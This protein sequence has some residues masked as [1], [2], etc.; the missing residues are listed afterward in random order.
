MA[1]CT[2][3]TVFSAAEV[4]AGEE[5]LLRSADALHQAYFDT[6]PEL[7][8]ALSGGPQY[9]GIDMSVS[10]DI[11]W[12]KRGFT[13]LPGLCVCI[14]VLTGLVIDLHVLSK[15]CHACEVNSKRI[16]HVVL[17]VW[18]AAH[19]RDCR[20]NHNQSSKAME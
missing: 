19:A 13:Y 3:L 1:Y 8:E 16:P 14:D 6:D 18:K 7:W 2:I 11:T 20:I 17:L 12:Q 4:E 15:Y 9:P 10:F 5:R